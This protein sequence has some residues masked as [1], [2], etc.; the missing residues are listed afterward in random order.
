MILT[1]GTPVMATGGFG[2]PCINNYIIITCHALFSLSVPL[3]SSHSICA[4]KKQI[5][6]IITALFALDPTTTNAEPEFKCFCRE[7][8]A[9]Y[10]A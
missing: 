9:Q 1:T 6:L 4:D 10:Q 8:R 7:N 3:R 5:L 2:A